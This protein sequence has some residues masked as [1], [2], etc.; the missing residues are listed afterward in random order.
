MRNRLLSALLAALML[1]A[2]IPC[3]RAADFTDTQGHWAQEYIEAVTAH[4]LFSGVTETEFAPDE[5]MTRAMF[6]TVLGRLED[7]DVSLWTLETTLFADVPL[8]TYYAPYVNWAACNGI[9]SGMSSSEFAPHDPVTREQMAKLVAYYA[10]RM[11]YDFLP[12]SET[13]PAAFDDAADIANYARD[14]VDALRVT[15]ILNGSLNSAGGMDFLPKSTATR[16]ECATVFC[17]LMESLQESLIPPEAPESITLSDA[18]LALTTAQTHTLTVEILPAGD[19]PYFRLWRSSDSSVASVN[20]SGVVTWQGVGTAIITVYTENG[21]SASCAVTCTAADLASADETYE[22]KCIR[23]FGEVVDDPRTYYPTTAEGRAAAEA[24]M[25]SITVA[26]W[27]LRSSGE[28]YTRY[29]TIRVHKNL[30]ATYEAIFSEIY[31]GEEQFPIHAL[32]GWGWSGRSEHTIG[33]AVDINPN[34]NYY[35]DPD[36]NAIVGS[37]W[38]PGEDPYSIPLDG[39]VARIFNKYG[40]TQGVNWRNGYKD[41]MHFSYFGT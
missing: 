41:Y 31:N 29:F 16:A 17:R 14:S 6:V 13:V 18:T 32:G 21:M 22:E 12:L 2:A 39:E 35:C 28:K 40:F 37:H 19:A 25:V 36:G 9:V 8:D 27:D 20:E 23:M 26:V 3:V 5:T 34:E 1:L 15:G 33:S 38:R 30:A 11:H 10:E 4:S 24:D 7:V